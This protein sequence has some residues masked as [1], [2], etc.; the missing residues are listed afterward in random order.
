[1]INPK[2][3]KEIGLSDSEAKIYL[4]LLKLGEATV[5]EISQS[6][7]LHRTNIYDGLEKLKEKGLV[8]YLSKENKQFFRAADPENLL[9]YLKEKENSILKLI[10]ELK[11]VQSKIDEKVTVEIFKGEQGLKSALKDILSKKK[12]VVGYSIA[13]QLRKHLPEFAKYYFREQTKYKINHRFIYTEGIIKPP[14]KFYQ[15]KYLPKEFKSTTVNLCYNNIILNLI[16]EPEIIAIRI[17]S[18]Q[19]SDNFKRHF[20]LLWKTAK[21]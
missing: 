10:P 17:T 16:W 18:K 15:I 20:E 5:V 14:S 7:G 8:S 21:K 11:A 2:N 12:E 1:M 6:S 3:L 19:L 13:G 4:S 9:N